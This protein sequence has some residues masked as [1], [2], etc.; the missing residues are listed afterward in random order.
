MD[1]LFDSFQRLDEQKNRNIEGTGPGI[2]ITHNLLLM[3]GSRL[4][5]RSVYG[6]GSTF[7]FSL[8]QKRIGQEKIGEFDIHHHAGMLRNA[9]ERYIYVPDA[10]IL[11]VDDNK[12]NL[13]VASGLLK[14][15]GVIPDTALSGKECIEL[16]KKNK[17]H[18]IFMDHMMPDMDGIETLKFIR[19]G[20][21]IGSDTAYG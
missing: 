6:Q 10:R 18:I 1:K 13:K 19:G 7:S 20:R 5:V 21:L 12:M 14:R 2:P 16:V 3:M 8:R 17:Y 11:I 9:R 15:N 4:E